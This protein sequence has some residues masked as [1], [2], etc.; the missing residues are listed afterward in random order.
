MERRH[1][2]VRALEQRRHV[3]HLDHDAE[4]GAR[5]PAETHEL[6]HGADLAHEDDDLGGITGA[7]VADE[8]A[9]PV[10]AAPQARV[11]AA[12]RGREVDVKG[13]RRREPVTG[14]P[15]RDRVDPQLRIGLGEEMRLDAAGGEPHAG[16]EHLHG[17]C[18]LARE[19]E[20]MQVDN[21]HRSR[22]VARA[23]RL[24]RPAS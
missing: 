11:T 18:P 6:A 20:L 13:G 22:P 15:G 10:P 17:V 7:M 23:P 1:V 3:V 21:D 24:F 19:E 12:A 8:R 9:E 4:A 16:V 14:E 5:E 2:V